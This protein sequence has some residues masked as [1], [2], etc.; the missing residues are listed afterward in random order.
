MDGLSPHFLL[1]SSFD[2]WYLVLQRSRM[3][4]KRFWKVSWEL[5]VIPRN[6]TRAWTFSVSPN[7]FRLGSVFLVSLDPENMLTLFFF[8][9]Q[10][11]SPFGTPNCQ[12][13][14]GQLQN[15][16]CKMYI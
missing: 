13:Y 6:F 12:V 5:K 11:D 8:G 15:F 10:F 1:A 3:S 16:C 9:I 2:R 4:S 7:S 14:K